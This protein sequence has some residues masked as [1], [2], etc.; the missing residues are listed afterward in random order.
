MGVRMLQTNLL[1]VALLA[2][3]A[4]AVE[5][6]NDDAAPADQT[7]PLDCYAATGAN[8]DRIPECGATK[9]CLPDDAGVAIDSGTCKAPNCDFGLTDERLTYDDGSTSVEMRFFPDISRA[10]T[11]EELAALFQEVYFNVS[12]PLEPAT[13][14][15]DSAA[16]LEHRG[17]IGAFD[18]FELKDGRL[19]VR[20]TFTI[21][22]PYT[23]VLSSAPGCITGDVGG[24]CE[25]RYG[26]ITRPG[27][28]DIELPTKP[29]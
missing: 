13:E 18:T 16:Y 14:H 22:D 19:H 15:A 6:A 5:K 26:G 8:A 29:L 3:S 9:V 4:C 17:G 23:Y 24:M 7:V 21:T 27:T 20:L 11:T 25:C 12:F 10:A 2:T 28:I 1:I